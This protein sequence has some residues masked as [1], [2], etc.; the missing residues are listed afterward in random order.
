MKQNKLLSPKIQSFD[1]NVQ[2][3][4]I[5]DKQMKLFRSYYFIVLQLIMVAIMFIATKTEAKYIDK[6]G[7][8]VAVIKLQKGDRL[9]TEKKLF[10][11]SFSRAYRNFTVNDLKVPDKDIKAFLSRAFQEEIDDLSKPGIHHYRINDEKGN[12]IAYFSIEDYDVLKRYSAD[13]NITSFPEHSYYLRQIY[14]VPSHKRLGIGKPILSH[15]IPDEFH[16]LQYIYLAVRRINIEAIQFYKAL[17]FSE[18][19]KSLHHLP[20]DRY[21]S[22]YYQ[23]SK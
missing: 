20:I 4:K 18:L 16:N 2:S 22:Y 3:M 5:K 10:L 6:L 9:E 13:S 15:I 23:K 7:R 21:A 11:E 14:V 1:I 19:D 17:G 8:P 12:L